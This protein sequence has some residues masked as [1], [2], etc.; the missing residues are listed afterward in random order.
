[1]AGMATDFSDFTCFH[2]L[3]RGLLKLGL[4]EDARWMHEAL[5]RAYSS[6]AEMLGEV[7]AMARRTH[8]GI[9]AVAAINLRSEFN[10]CVQLVRTAWP[11]FSL[12]ADRPNDSPIRRN[13][14]PDFVVSIPA[15]AERAEKC[16]RRIS[17]R[18]RQPACVG[19]ADRILARPLTLSLSPEYRPSITRALR[20]GEG[21]KQEMFFSR[22]PG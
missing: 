6:S 2:E 9:P 18:G 8:R 14:Y 15:T 19:G 10:A 16:D 5:T 1:M 20:G 11:E 22:S 21:T 12:T 17:I 13:D 3:E 4:V 7:G